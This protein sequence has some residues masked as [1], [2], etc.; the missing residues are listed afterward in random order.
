[1]LIVPTPSDHLNVGEVICEGTQGTSSLDVA[2]M[3]WYLGGA[4]ER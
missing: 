4:R 1:M 2:H 3:H